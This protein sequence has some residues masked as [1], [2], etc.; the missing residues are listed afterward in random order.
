MA[1]TGLSNLDM[2]FTKW[3][4][5]LLKSYYPYFLNYIIIYE[6]PWVLNTAFKIIK[7]WLPAKAIQR[8][9]FVDKKTLKDFVDADNALTCWG[10][11]DNYV[12]TFVP[13]VRNNT[14][15][16][17]GKFENTKKVI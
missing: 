12:F 10:G 3:L 7:S 4:I 16:T 5:G 11:N 17:N 9:K 8:V 6:M 13:E 14:A 15:F 1:D 2:E